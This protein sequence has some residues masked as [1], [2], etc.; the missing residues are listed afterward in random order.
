[1]WL[2]REL[3]NI[4]ARGAINIALLTELKNEGH[5]FEAIVLSALVPQQTRTAGS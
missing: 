5:W 4:L 3:V 2:L 1:M